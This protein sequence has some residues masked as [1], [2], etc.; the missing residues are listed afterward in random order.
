MSLASAAALLHWFKHNHHAVGVGEVSA[1]M[2]WPKST[3]SRLLKS[4]QQHGLLDRDPATGRYRPGLLLLELASGYRE[5]EPL[6]EAADNALAE[7]TRRTGHATGISM[8][9]GT[10]V[11]VLRSRPGTQPLRVVTP[12]GSRGPAWA[13]STGRALLARLADDE[14]ALRFRRFPKPP[15]PAAPQSLSALMQRI[16]RVRSLGWEEACDEQIAGLGGVSVAVA[17]PATGD[18]VALY[19]AFS[20]LH[21][22]RQERRDLAGRLLEVA[23]DLARRF[24]DAAHAGLLRPAVRSAH[25]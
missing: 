20:A 13:T 14:I 9:D 23:A 8:L 10:E 17:E 12:P 19:F 2:G 11:V 15:R 18:A 21:V 1:A 3:T 6:V 5:G 24:G 25:G 7:E 16:K 4:M 22:N